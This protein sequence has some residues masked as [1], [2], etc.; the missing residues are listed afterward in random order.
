MSGRKVGGILIVLFV[1][2]LIAALVDGG[3]QPLRPTEQAI[4]L[5]EAAR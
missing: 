4:E 2:L 1:V 3:E 5:P